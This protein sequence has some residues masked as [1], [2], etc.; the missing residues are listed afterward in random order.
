MHRV[1]ALAGLPLRLPMLVLLLTGAGGCDS[2]PHRPV[3]SVRTVTL[4]PGPHPVAAVRVKDLGTIRIELYPEAAP[5]TVAQFEQLAG[6]GF[7]DGT[8]FHRVIPGFM[9]QGGCPNTRNA[10]PRD[11]GSGGGDHVLEDE[12]NDL[13]H[14][15]GALAM[16]NR[17]SRNSGGTQFFVVS[18]DSS[19]LD[20]K[21]TVFGQVI[22]GI[23]VVDA[24]TRLEIDKFGR[25]GP[26]DRP[27]PVSAVV[28]SIRMEPRP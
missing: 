2:E 7:Y 16:A 8:T 28:E 25:Y 20:G 26:P 4:S 11:D 17:G 22:E 12:F 18:A 3:A 27:Y 15:R 19:N 24:I 14:R 6:E 23:E 9:I 5:K 10:D 21:H 1:R 13:P